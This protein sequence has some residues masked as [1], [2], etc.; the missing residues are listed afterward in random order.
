MEINIHNSTVIVAPLHWGLGHAS[1]CIPVINR[2]TEQN[3]RVILAS[4]GLALTYLQSIFPTLTTCQLPSYNISYNKGRWNSFYLGL[5]L[6]GINK[7]IKNERAAIEKICK[8]E[9]PQYIIS[10]NRYGAYSHSCSNI[11]ITHQ[12]QFILKWPVN[13]LAPLLSRRVRAMVNKFDECWVPDTGDSINNFSGI[14]AYGKLKAAKKYIGPLSSF[15]NLQFTEP[16]KPKYDFCII[17]TGPELQRSVFENLIVQ[18]LNHTSYTAIVI[19]STTTP[20]KVEIKNTGLKFVDIASPSLVGQSMIESRYVISRPG[21]TTI[22]DLA[23][24]NRKCVLV[25]TPGQPEQVYLSRRMKSLN[26][27]VVFNQ[28]EM[29]FDDLETQLQKTDTIHNYYKWLK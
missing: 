10:D 16:T 1:R 2:L 3:C 19:R 17:I 6:K 20:L 29:M 9:N 28:T 15:S 27:A 7:V 5:Q 23:Y 22:M 4:D 14:M 18:K 24:I 21:Y 8:A 25:P 13:I 11:I 26:L 12:L